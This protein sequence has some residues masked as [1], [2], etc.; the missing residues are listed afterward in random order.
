M[1]TTFSGDS[2]YNKGYIAFFDIDRTITKAISGRA[3]ARGAFTKGLITRLDIVQ[4]GYLSLAYR[5][6][7][8]DPLKIIDRMV[9]WLD[10][11]PEKTIDDL[12]SEVFREVLYPSVYDEARFEIKTHKE[13]NAKVVILSSTLTPICR[14]MAENLGMDDIIC[15]ALE[16]E[17]GYFTGHPIGHLCFGKE[18]AIRLKSYC[19]INNTKMSEAWYYGDSTSDLPALSLVGNPVCINPDRKLKKAAQKRGWK[20]LDWNS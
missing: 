15:S 4:A 17:N 13:K 5:L 20:I 10:G 16:V 8:R 14:Y 6:N 19:E 1:A 2:N 7:L 11:I 9:T 18:K 3:L 12:C